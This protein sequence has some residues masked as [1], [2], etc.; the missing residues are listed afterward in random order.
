MAWIPLNMS[1]YAKIYQ[2]SI[3]NIENNSFREKNFWS[4]IKTFGP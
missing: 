4:E 1:K 3:K 2:N